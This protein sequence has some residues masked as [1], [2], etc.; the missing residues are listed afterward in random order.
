VFDALVSQRPYK[1]PWRTEDAFAEIE[2]VAGSHFDPAIATAFV[3]CRPGVTEVMKRFAD[4]QT[5]A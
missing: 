4:A 3:E 5:A 1:R 2:R